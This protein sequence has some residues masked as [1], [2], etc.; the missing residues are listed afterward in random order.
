MTMMMNNKFGLQMMPFEMDENVYVCTV[1]YRTE[2]V[3]LF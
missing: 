2:S 1:A 3:F